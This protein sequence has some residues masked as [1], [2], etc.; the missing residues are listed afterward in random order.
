MAAIALD[1]V[2]RAHESAARRWPRVRLDRDALASHLER[3]A[4]K[5]D[6][7]LIPTDHLADV[8]LACACALADR[9]AL[10]VFER[11]L[12]P[13]VPAYLARIDGPPTLADD[14]QQELRDK[15]LVA[16]AGAFPRIADY[17]GDGPIE[18]WLRIVAIR[19]ALKLL[20]PTREQRHVDPAADAAAAVATVDPELELVWARHRV[21]FEHAVR[22][23]FS[24][25]P[26]ADRMLLR[27][28]FVDGLEL[29]ALAALQHTHRS[30]VV[31]R[32]AAARA[33]MVD[34]LRRILRD[35]S[36]L[37]ASEIRSLVVLLRS[38]LEVTLRTV[39]EQ[40]AV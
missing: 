31:R 39:D 16:E 7:S 28:R 3:L 34:E 5:R 1:V 21:D 25:L 30:T 12:L 29:P 24:A 35:R 14:V 2:D 10:D 37:T 15:L 27:L 8:A 20:R 6:G 19:T 17:G 23:A 26:P 33:H 18:G 4:S 40:P 32:L 22:A 36:K 13:R 9:G 11:E 38:R